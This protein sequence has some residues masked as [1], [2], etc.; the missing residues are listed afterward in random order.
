MEEELSERWLVLGMVIVQSQV[1]GARSRGSDLP[2][3]RGGQ[4]AAFFLA[5]GAVFSG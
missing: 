3:G 4:H 5:Y 2:Q 1:V